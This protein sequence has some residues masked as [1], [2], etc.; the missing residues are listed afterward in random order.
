MADA[1][2]RLF[3]TSLTKFYIFIFYKYVIKILY[4]SLENHEVL[5]LFN[6]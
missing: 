3:I 1:I 6:T 2:E 4:Y 5:P